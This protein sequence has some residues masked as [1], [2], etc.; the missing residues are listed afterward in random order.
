MPVLSLSSLLLD[1]PP[2]LTQVNAN[3]FSMHAVPK[4]RFNFLLI[5]GLSRWLLSCDRP[6]R[7]VRQ[8]DVSMP[9]SASV[10]C[11]HLH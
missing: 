10:L 7:L 8:A 11:S 1:L 2:W 4:E 6:Q 9:S 3:V 5:K